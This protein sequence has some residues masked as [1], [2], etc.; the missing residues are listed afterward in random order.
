MVICCLASVLASLERLATSFLS[1]WA[2]FRWVLQALRISHAVY[3]LVL[4]ESSCAFCFFL[5]CVP[6]SHLSCFGC[7][8]LMMFCQCAV[9]PS[10]RKR[11]C[12]SSSICG[13][14]IMHC[15]DLFPICVVWCAFRGCKAHL[16]RISFVSYPVIKCRYPFFFSSL[17]PVSLS[18]AVDVFSSL[19]FCLSSF[20]LFSTRR[21]QTAT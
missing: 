14:C 20:S 17:F 7:K 2:R 6:F 12:S 15:R 8:I 5:V 3:S 19:L 21:A 11:P 13:S 16:M 10:I 4:R 18:R 1:S 9:F